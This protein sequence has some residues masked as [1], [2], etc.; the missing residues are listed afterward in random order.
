MKC[1]SFIH[2]CPGIPRESPCLRKLQDVLQAAVPCFLLLPPSCRP[3]GSDYGGAL[4]GSASGSAEHPVTA[5]G[6]GV[7]A[8][9]ALLTG[10][11]MSFFHSQPAP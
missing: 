5:R 10:E 2:L 3:E 4:R 6:A 9:V 8:L 7:F 11:V 1:T